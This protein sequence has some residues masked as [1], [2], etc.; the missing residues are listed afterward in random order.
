MQYCNS[1][2]GTGGTGTRKTS[3]MPLPPTHQPRVPATL[4]KSKPLGLLYTVQCCALSKSV[5]QCSTVQCSREQYSAVQPT[6]LRP[7]CPRSADQLMRGWTPASLGQAAGTG[8]WCWALHSVQ[9][10]VLGTLHGRPMGGQSWCHVTRPGHLGGCGPMGG[11]RQP[12]SGVDGPVSYPQSVADLPGVTVS[13]PYR[14]QER[15]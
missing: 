13:T 10:T 3:Y 7:D 4:P 1:V 5:L 2:P 11:R 12:G 9:C 15:N 14:G 6:T 8:S